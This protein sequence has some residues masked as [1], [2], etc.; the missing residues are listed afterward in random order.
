MIILVFGSIELFNAQQGI[1]N[2]AKAYDQQ[3][4]RY[5]ANYVQMY[6]DDITGEAD[7][8]STSPDT[9]RAIKGRDIP[10]L[11]EIANNLKRYNARS[12]VVS[13]IDGD[14]NILYS[15]KNINISTIR[16]YDW[17]AEA[18]KSQTA[19]VTGIYNSSELNDYAIALLD[20]IQDDHTILGRTM[21]VILPDTLQDDIQSQVV[22]PYENILI[23]DRNGRIISHD[24][25]TKT[26]LYTNVSSDI[27]VHEVLQGKEGV[28]EDSDAWDHQA[29]ISAYFPTPDLGWGVIVS[30]PTKFV[31]DSLENEARMMLGMLAI[32]VIGLLV[33]G[34]FVSNYLT[35]PIIHLSETM[36]NIS[37]GNYRERARIERTYEIGDLALQFNAMMDDLEQAQNE[38]K[39]AKESAEL[40]VDILGHDINNMNQ[41]AIGYIE[42]TLDS[43]RDEN[44]HRSLLEKTREMLFNS[45]TLIENVRKIQRIKAGE[46]K[47][48]IIDLDQLLKAI[49]DKYSVVQGR[50]IRINYDA[51]CECT[52]LASELLRDVFANLITNSIKHSTGPLAIDVNMTSTQENGK[53]FCKVA[54]SDTG[55]GIPDNIKKVLFNRFSRGSTEAKG[56]GLGLYIVKSLVENFKGR[57]WV[58]DRVPG[59]YRGG[60]RFIVVLPEFDHG[61][62]S[63]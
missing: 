17:Y 57:V 23:V 19:Y 44:C 9:V 34:F 42:L 47:P 48:E 37:H 3:D 13:F 5:L 10:H 50:D 6:M 8:V 14:G 56:S 60:C 26:E 53:A 59:D 18:S 24:D 15:T 58:E 54:V 20:P 38:R 30:T 35:A 21:I 62:D 43:L 11:N 41:V 55:P 28:I 33:L 40:Y 36:R 31:Y 61:K 46:V 22:N 12:V 39:N 1:K 25:R 49:I 32:F 51:E 45:S 7:I 63:L 29:R 2:D 27:A 4:S 16:S 52:V